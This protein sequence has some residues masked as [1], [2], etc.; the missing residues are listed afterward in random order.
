M[1][2]TSRLSVTMIA[3]IIFCCGLPALAQRDAFLRDIPKPAKDSTICF[4]LYTVN[5]SILKLTA[6]LYPLDEGNPRTVRVEMHRVRAA[7]GDRIAVL[8]A[9]GGA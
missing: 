2:G 7:L 6:Q 4:C 9:A 3:V 5:N 8:D 1:T